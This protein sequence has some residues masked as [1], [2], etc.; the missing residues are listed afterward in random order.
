MLRQ[1][2]HRP[3]CRLCPRSL[4]RIANINSVIDI[5]SFAIAPVAW[6]KRQISVDFNQQGSSSL[7]CI[8]FVNAVMNIFAAAI[9]PAALQ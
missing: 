8:A 2:C 9:T 7:T 5:T 1:N 4:A 3:G 6:Y